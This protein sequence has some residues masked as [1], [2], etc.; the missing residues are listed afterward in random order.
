MSIHREDLISLNC[1]AT[2]A[3][4]AFGTAVPID[5]RRYIYKIHTLNLFNGVNIL[6]VSW[7]PAGGVT[8]NFET[9][10][11][12]LQY[13]QYVDPEDG[14]QENALPLYVINGTT[15]LVNFLWLTTSAGNCTV[16]VWYEDG[17]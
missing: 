5:M 8:A 14:V 16:T 15:E 13:D 1:A 10:A 3:A 17:Y 12:V 2:I 11:H 6:T 4:T 9:I 7:G